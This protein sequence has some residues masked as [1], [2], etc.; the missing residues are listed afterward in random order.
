MVQRRSCRSFQAAAR[1]K[2]THFYRPKHT[3]SLNLKPMPKAP[4]PAAAK[5]LSPADGG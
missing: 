5:P 4:N 2:E 1:K 3:L